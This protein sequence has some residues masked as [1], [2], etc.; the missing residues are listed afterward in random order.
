M[1]F[2]ISQQET[3]NALER[4]RAG[5]H[6]LSHFLWSPGQSMQ[7]SIKGTLCSLL[8]QICQTTE[9]CAEALLQSHQDLRLKDSPSDWATAELREL[10]LR[11]FRASTT[12]Y[13]IFLDGLDEVCPEDG[14]GDILDFVQELQSLSQLKLCIASRPE[15]VFKRRLA[16][17]PRLEVQQLTANDLSLYAK[18]LLSRA[19][20]QEA[21]KDAYDRLII[22]LLYKAQGVFLWL[23][24]AVKSLR[25]GI[26]NKDSLQQLQKR[27]DTMPDDLATLYEDMWLRL[28]EDR[29]IYRQTASLYFQ[30]VLAAR[31]CTLI[32]EPSVFELAVAADDDIQAALGPEQRL[33]SLS[34]NALER[35]CRATINDVEVRCAGLLEIT[36]GYDDPWKPPGIYTT[37][38]PYKSLKIDFIHRTAY[39]FLLT[40]ADGQAILLS[41]SLLPPPSVRLFRGCLSNCLLPNRRDRMIE[42]ETPPVKPFFEYLKQLQGQNKINEADTIDSLLRCRVLYDAR[43][44]TFYI[45]EPRTE[46]NRSCGPNFL[47]L[48]AAYGFGSAVLSILQNSMGHQT[49]NPEFLSY[50][51]HK[52]CHFNYGHSLDRCRLIQFLLKMGANPDY[53]GHTFSNSLAM[54]PLSCIGLAFCS[55]FHGPWRGV[56]G[57]RGSDQ[58]EGKALL[59][60]LQHCLEIGVDLKSQALVAVIGD[61]EDSSLAY[62]L[63]MMGDVAGHSRCNVWDKTH[64]AA[65]LLLEVDLSTFLDM[66]LCRLPRSC[67]LDALD[68][69]CEG[70]S[71]S[72]RVCYVRAFRASNNRYYVTTSA[73][74]S[75]YLISIIHPWLFGRDDGSLRNERDGEGL[76][77]SKLDQGRIATRLYEATLELMSQSQ[78]LDNTEDYMKGLGYLHTTRKD[79]YA[80]D[81]LQFL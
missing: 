35:S 54:G 9:G 27:L 58:Q 68:I 52:A 78:P 34:P 44:L 24:L 55:I 6:L 30:L 63:E 8:Y 81:M 31:D 29:M 40:T 21:V 5:T 47:G 15:H 43:C 51:L 76:P 70:T 11:F 37:L 49:W 61:V 66:F 38:L 50:L 45:N 80:S 18:S 16:I 22:E 64:R 33:G 65:G 10:V 42:L 60:M 1:K 28:N 2:I 59:G 7:R 67:Q 79:L 46:K 32:S 57:P 39:D 13:C 53:R 4:W 72:P 20:I 48:A 3:L 23:A 73:E 12:P 69:L 17:F 19:D 71:F 26:D 25:R 36:V 77:L 75:A 41:R 56:V 14:V 62:S 74:D